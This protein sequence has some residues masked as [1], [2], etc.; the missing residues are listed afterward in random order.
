MEAFSVCILNLHSSDLLC[1]SLWYSLALPGSLKSWSKQESSKRCFSLTQNCAICNRQEPSEAYPRRVFNS[2]QSGQAGRWSWGDIQGN[3]Q[4]RTPLSMGHPCQHQWVAFNPWLQ[5]NFRNVPSHIP[6]QK[7]RELR[8][9]TK[10]CG[11]SVCVTSETLPGE[12]ARWFLHALFSYSW[13]LGHSWRANSFLGLIIHWNET[14]VP[15]V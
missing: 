15:R 3:K 5:D 9:N 12:P 1:C 6:G 14:G 13:V 2:C 8:E 10:A 11:R 4:H 7:W